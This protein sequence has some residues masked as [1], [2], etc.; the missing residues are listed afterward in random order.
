MTLANLT[1]SFLFA[2]ALLLGGAAAVAADEP[3]DGLLGGAVDGATDLVG[4]GAATVAELPVVKDVPVEPVVEVVKVVVPPATKPVA[5]VASVVA[6]VVAPAP[7]VVKPV[8][9]AA[10]PVTQ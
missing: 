5:P 8:A 6:R 10:A 1:R 4:S 3:G 9:E 2:T 7:K